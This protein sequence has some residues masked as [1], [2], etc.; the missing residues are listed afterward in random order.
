[1][2]ASMA[3]EKNRSTIDAINEFVHDTLLNFEDK[4]CTLAVFWDL[5]K[6]FDTIDDSLLVKKL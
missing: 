6:A 5:S 1:M 3:S 2:R 4:K